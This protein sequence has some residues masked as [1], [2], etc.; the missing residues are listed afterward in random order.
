M[1][2]IRWWWWRRWSLRFLV[3]RGLHHPFILIHHRKDNTKSVSSLSLPSLSLSLSR[4]RRRRRERKRERCKKRRWFF[5]SED[6]DFFPERFTITERRDSRHTLWRRRETTQ[7]RRNN[8]KKDADDEVRTRAPV[9]YSVTVMYHCYSQCSC[10]LGYLNAEIE[11][12]VD[13]WFIVDRIAAE[14]LNHSATS[15]LVYITQ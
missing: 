5:Y 3:V 1:N 2:N 6:D 15:A 10:M 9:G 12:S 13:S 14:R 8:K 7:R 11:I 4:R